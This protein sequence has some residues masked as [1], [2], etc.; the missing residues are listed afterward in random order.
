M[1]LSVLQDIL[2][3][4]AGYLNLDPA[5]VLLYIGIICTGCNIVGRLIPDDAT[6]VVGQVRDIV[7]MIGFYAPNRVSRGVTVNDVV[8]QVIGAGDSNRVVE[9]AKDD[10]ALVPEVVEDRKIVPAFPGRAGPNRGPD[11]KFVPKK[12]DES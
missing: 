5:T 11:G 4:L 7:K 10:D 3:D 8:N 1:D 2:P 9:M 12:G 6:G